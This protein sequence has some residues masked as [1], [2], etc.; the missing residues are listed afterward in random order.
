MRPS[1]SGVV[2]A[3]DEEAMLADCL[4]SLSFADEL[5]VLVDAATR[6]ATRE[7]A[8]SH[9]ARVAERAFVNFAEQR[10]A[11]LQL[12]ATEWVL[13]V[14]ADERVTPS[15]EA[16]VLASI[17]QPDGKRGFWI[18][19]LNYLMGRVVRHAG[20]YP[21]YQLR[22]LARDFS[23]FAR[24]VHEVAVVDGPVGH[25]REPFVHYNYRT[26]AEF[27]RKQERYCRLDAEQWLAEFGAPRARALLGQPARE[28]WRRY[29]ALTG[30]RDGLLGLILSLLLAWYR[31]K[32]I[33]LA[34]QRAD[35]PGQA[36][37]AARPRS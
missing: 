12:C 15:L 10:D 19:R 32:A 37:P 34:R 4:R 14:D 11:A 31:A 28:F 22:L 25:L 27:V 35:R 13:F 9:G 2:I 20:W 36:L 3:R 1:L 23:H 6:D 17:E 33:W 16:E 26:L 30:Y 8:A 24:A 29:I 21:D 18:P 7:V 5:L